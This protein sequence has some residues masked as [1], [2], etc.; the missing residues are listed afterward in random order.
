MFFFFRLWLNFTNDTYF[1]ILVFIWRCNCCEKLKKKANRYIYMHCTH[2]YILWQFFIAEKR[3]IYWWFNSSCTLVCLRYFAL[4]SVGSVCFFTLRNAKVSSQSQ[5]RNSPNFSYTRDFQHQRHA[6]G[7][8]FL[9]REKNVQLCSEIS[10]T[11]G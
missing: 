9:C 10:L 3:V 4:S 8:A 6:G 11:I 7:R 2:L 1:V 5:P